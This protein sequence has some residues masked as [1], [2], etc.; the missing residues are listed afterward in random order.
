MTDLLFHTDELDGVTDGPWDGGAGGV[1]RLSARRVPAAAT[2]AAIGWTVVDARDGGD[3]A[4]GW[5]ALQ[6]AFF[7]EDAAWLPGRVTSP[8]RLG[9]GGC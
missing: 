3:D 7:A 5:R 6:A 9:P 2:G 8:G 4:E 1:A